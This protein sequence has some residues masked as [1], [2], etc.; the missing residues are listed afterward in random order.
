MR[1]GAD[2]QVQLE[3]RVPG[4]GTQ[5]GSP[6]SGHELELAS[7]WT[8]QEGLVAVSPDMI[9]HLGRSSELRG[10]TS[11]EVWTEGWMVR[12]ALVQG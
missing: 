4:I 8:N 6:G 12:Q 5:M 11:R 10:S 3:F 9:R 2:S 1:C 7:L